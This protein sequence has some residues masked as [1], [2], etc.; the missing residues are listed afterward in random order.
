MPLGTTDT[1]LMDWVKQVELLVH[2]DGPSE[3]RRGGVRPD[4]WRAIGQRLSSSPA[5]NRAADDGSG[6][7]RRRRRIRL[8]CPPE[9]KACARRRGPARGFPFFYEKTGL[10]FIY[11]SDSLHPRSYKISLKETKIAS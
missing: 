1:A 9:P 3:T 8:L 11:F 4:W 5:R 7:R 2:R 6:W 10:H